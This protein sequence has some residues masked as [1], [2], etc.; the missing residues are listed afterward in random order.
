[1]KKIIMLAIVI[2]ILLPTAT[3]L[4]NES[5]LERL[6]IEERD[7]RQQEPRVSDK[8][9]EPNPGNLDPIHASES[10]AK[11]THKIFATSRAWA[12]PAMVI[13]WLAGGIIWGA[14]AFAGTP[15][16]RGPGLMLFGTGMYVLIHAAPIVV[17][18]FLRYLES[19]QFF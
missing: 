6:I 10:A 18:T 11:T 1:M 4:A 19:T 5:T 2:A 15:Q 14:G 16:N 7:R 9:R 12:L 17:A 8:I 13:T 3:T